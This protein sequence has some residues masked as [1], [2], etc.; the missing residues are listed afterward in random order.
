MDLELIGRRALVLASSGGLGLAVATELA[1]EG[2]RVM[3]SSR[4]QERARAAADGLPGGPHLAHQVDVSDAE[5]LAGL[6]GAAADALGGID[7]LV[8]NAGGPPPGNFADLD[9][10]KWEAAFNLT[11]MSVVRGI[12][13][14]LPHMGEGA[15]IL[16]LGSSS[17]V[18]PI[19]G[20][21]LS[22]AFR[23]GVHAIIKHLASELAPRGIR[24]NLLSPGRIHTDRIEQL[25]QA[26]AERQ[27]A[28]VEDIR[29]RS[30]A[31]IPLG[32]LGQPAEFGKVGAFLLSGAA[33]YVTGASW[34]VDGGMVKSL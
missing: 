20:L 9:D 10:S 29:R 30:E 12:R 7:I 2:A 22:N 24:A 17:V 21:L 8:L 28:S 25:D 33:S 14:A 1:A 16:A 32:R 13:A 5:S 3:L 19:P 11:L 31:A 6:V 26:A 23:P 4:S 27:G 15:S 18:Q 34:L